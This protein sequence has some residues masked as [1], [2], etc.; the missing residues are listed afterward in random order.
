[1]GETLVGV[2]THF[3]HKPMVA[4]VKIESGAVKVGDRLHF[5]GHSTD[6]FDVVGS[7]QV[8]NNP[9][10]EAKSGDLI[11]IKVKDRVREHDQV[12]VV[13]GETA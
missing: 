12:M 3:F 8:D 7:M 1:M 13:T 9:V 2:V 10:Q 4:A 11:G 5:K 6:F